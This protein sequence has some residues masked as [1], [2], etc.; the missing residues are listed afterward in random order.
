MDGAKPGHTVKFQGLKGAAHLN[1]TEGTLVKYMKNQG[2][3][4]VRCED[5]GAL[6]CA[7]PEN[8]I[9]K[10][11]KPAKEEPV[12]RVISDEELFKVPSLSE[13][14]DDCPI[15]CIP[16]DL[17]EESRIFKE[18]CGKIICIGCAHRM[19]TNNCGR[20]QDHPCPFCRTP[21]CKNDHE[22]LQRV[23]KLMN[24]NNTNIDSKRVALFEMGYYYR[25]GKHGVLQ[26]YSRSIEY[27][28][29]SAQLGYADANHNLGCAYHHGDGV[30][31]DQKMVVYY[32]S[33]AA[34]QGSSKA[35]HS[36]ASYVFNVDKDIKRAMKH[37]RIAAEQ[38]NP[39]SMATIT[40]GVL[41]GYVTKAEYDEILTIHNQVLE[42]K[43]S[44]QRD[45][46]RRI[47]GITT[48]DEDPDRT[49]VARIVAQMNGDDDIT[50][51]LSRLGM[52]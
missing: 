32:W 46:A 49:N 29:R 52:R 48:H 2:R 7:K 26:S 15:C 43:K 9:R 17:D 25:E 19:T 8:L 37:Y 23:E 11:M 3:W 13:G 40:S 21:Y 44:D 42:S 47:I 39:D 4:S 36:L 10:Y 50:S 41:R 20:M 1:D 33:L 22:Y 24:E 31:K 14:D 28:I 51:V 27:M 12:L 5:D 45:R 30:K 16:L 38:G 34:I 18:C 35:R 6:V